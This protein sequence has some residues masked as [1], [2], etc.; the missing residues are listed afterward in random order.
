MTQAPD[1]SLRDEPISVSDESTVVAEF[2]P[3]EGRGSAYQSEAELEAAFIKLLQGNSVRVSADQE[4]RRPGGEPTT[5]TRGA[6]QDRV[7]RRGVE[8]AFH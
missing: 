6:E 8:A 2:L 3:E 5:P 1:S 4:C 7:Q